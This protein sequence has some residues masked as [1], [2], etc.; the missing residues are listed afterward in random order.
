[1]AYT[2]SCVLAQAVS[3]EVATTVRIEPSTGPAQ[4]VQTRPS[5]VPS[6]KPPRLP[7]RDAA[8]PAAALVSPP[9]RLDSHSNGA[10]QIISTPKPAS[11]IAAPVRRLLGSK[12]KIRVIALNSKAVAENE[13][14]NPSAI[15]AGRILPVWPTDA[16]SRIGS[17]GSV[18]GAA[19]VTMPASSARRRFN[20]NGTHRSARI[21]AGTAVLRRRALNVTSAASRIR[22]LVASGAPKRRATR[23]G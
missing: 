7:W 8:L 6:T 20:I 9:S 23:R 10:G 5:V 2:T 19:T 15:I 16:P 3:L 11:R 17:I 22:E 4:G 13:M 14:T 1:M 12:S 18:Q 21:R